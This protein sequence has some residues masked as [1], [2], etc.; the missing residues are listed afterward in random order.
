MVFLEMEKEELNGEEINNMSPE[1]LASFLF[2][3]FLIIHVYQR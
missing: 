1:V 3:L 2:M